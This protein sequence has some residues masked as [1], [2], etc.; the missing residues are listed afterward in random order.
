[1]PTTQINIVSDQTIPNILFIKQFAA[2]TNHYL[3]VST[4]KMNQNGQLQA[5]I[6]V[7]GI[8]AN[9]YQTIT[10]NEESLTDVETQLEELRLSR[11]HQYIVNITGGTKIMSIGVYNFFSHLNS[12]IYYIPIGNNQYKKIFPPANEQTQALNYQVSLAEYLQ[13]YGIEVLNS[14]VFNGLVQPP[15]VSQKLLATRRNS[16]IRRG[17]AAL[18]NYK[19]DCEKNRIPFISVNLQ[20]LPPNLLPLLNTLNYIGFVPQTPNVL[21]EQEINYLLGQWLEEYV[22][23][24]IR[25][26]FNLADP[27]I[28]NSV[29]IKRRGV[30]NEFDVMFI[31]KNAIY[32]IECKTS[33]NKPMFDQTAYK[34]NALKKEFGLF[35]KSALI[36]ADNYKDITGRLSL[37][38]IRLIDGSIA[39]NKHLFLTQLHQFIK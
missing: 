30:E 26:E 32:V 34:L 9:S 8:A 5:I 35:V 28:G 22:Y 33:I 3:F 37:F 13:G 36:C 7:C 19:M 18:R 31:Y 17:L 39:R 24:T 10:V 12:S 23:T 29:Y 1:M 2:Q 16:N 25:Q 11:S 21:C 38:D 4:P 14:A 6:D 20:A 15:A 27:F